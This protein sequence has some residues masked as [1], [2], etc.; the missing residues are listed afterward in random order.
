MRE[1]DMYYGGLKMKRNW[2]GTPKWYAKFKINNEIRWMKVSNREIKNLLKQY[3]NRYQMIYSAS[4]FDHENFRFKFTVVVDE[5]VDLMIPCDTCDVQFYYTM[6]KMF[7][8]KLLVN[9]K[10]S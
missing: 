9:S 4:T 7:E 8:L 1:I 3:G 5:K 10:K 6:F 2:F